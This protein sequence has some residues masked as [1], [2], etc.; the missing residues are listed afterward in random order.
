MNNK[1]KHNIIFQK[2]KAIR[3]FFEIQQNKK[4]NT[5]QNT[6]D[7]VDWIYFF[8]YDGWIL[9]NKNS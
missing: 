8:F 7:M 5:K 9:Q 4:Q 1:E 3:S 6:I 2:S